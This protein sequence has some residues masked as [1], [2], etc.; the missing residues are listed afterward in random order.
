MLRTHLLYQSRLLPLSLNIALEGAQDGKK[1]AQVTL[2][3]MTSQP[4]V[5]DSG[6]TG[7]W[8]NLSFCL[9]STSEKVFVQC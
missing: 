3:L 4:G 8:L 1:P 9:G 6:P 7:Q 5:L 2:F